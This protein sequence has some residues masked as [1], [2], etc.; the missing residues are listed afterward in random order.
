MNT[1][2]SDGVAAVNNGSP[3]NI[4]NEIIKDNIVD[5]VLYDTA[6]FDDTAIKQL[7]S[8]NEINVD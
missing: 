4:T 8:D 2:T 3:Q 5:L 6:N 7:P 1:L